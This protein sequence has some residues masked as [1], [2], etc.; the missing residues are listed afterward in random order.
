VVKITKSRVAE[1][2]P[3]GSA[4]ILEITEFPHNRAEESLHTKNQ[5]DPSISFDRTQTCDRDTDIDTGS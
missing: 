1:K 4:L 3:E 5:L 2:V